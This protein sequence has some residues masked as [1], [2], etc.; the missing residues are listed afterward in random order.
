MIVCMA[1]DGFMLKV[2]GLKEMGRCKLII[3]LNGFLKDGILF[4]T[5]QKFG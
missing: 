2:E 3:Q 1:K 4:K 5:I